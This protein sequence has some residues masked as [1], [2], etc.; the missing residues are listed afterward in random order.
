LRR[1]LREHRSGESENECE[2]NF[3]EP[4]SFRLTHSRA[5]SVLGSARLQ[6]AGRRILRRRTLF[7]SKLIH[8]RKTRPE[9]FAIAECDRQHASERALPRIKR[10]RLLCHATLDFLW[11]T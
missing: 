8:T 9:K 2:Q 11:L 1:R 6:R 3:H 4:K 10:A 7:D 5:R